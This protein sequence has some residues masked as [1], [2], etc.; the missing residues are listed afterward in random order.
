MKKTK[1]ERNVS[2][3]VVLNNEV[4]E[5]VDDGKYIGSQITNNDDHPS[6]QEAKISKASTSFK[7]LY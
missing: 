5:N 2:E 7:G 3:K 4:I 1:E 6:D